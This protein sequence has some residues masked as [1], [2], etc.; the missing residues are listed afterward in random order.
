MKAAQYSQYGD[1]DVI[2]I[3]DAEKPVPQ[4]GQVLIEV[5]AAAPNPFDYKVRRGYMKD[6]IPVQFPVTIGADFAG[7]V[8]GI[9]EDAGDIQVGDEVFGSA[10]VLNGG[11]GAVADYAAANVASIA[12]KPSNTGFEE[13]AAIVLVGVSATQALDQLD[14]SEGKK[15]LIHGGAGG[16][17]S[18]A[19]QYA[20]QLGAHVATAVKAK[21]FDFVKGLGADEVIDYEVQ[22][23]EDM[24]KDY[25]AVYD[26]IGGDTYL[27]SFKILKP[28][29]KIISMNE[30]PNKEL[31]AKHQVTALH[32]SADVNTESL[33]K[34]RDL[35][36]RSV[37]KPQI[38]KI[39][40]L[41]QAAEAFRCL[42]TEH[43]QGKVVISIQ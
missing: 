1:A 41:D 18:T 12:K 19:I 2:E 30:Q 9:G 17:G 38:A 5:K 7:V 21:D 43:P 14:L 3:K 34:V 23:F 33:G 36:E 11:S 13:A 42:E 31:A 28:G 26:T 35:V 8:T 37:I 20:K 40:P 25:D 15:I 29:G 39:F 24:L 32:L 22:Q 10:I 16:I 4:P 6:V 27:R